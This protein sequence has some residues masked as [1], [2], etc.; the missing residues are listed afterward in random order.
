VNNNHKLQE[1]L[2]LAGV[3]VVNK[4]ILPSTASARV[5]KDHFFVLEG[6]KFSLLTAAF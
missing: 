3:F 4:I 2:N 6:R 5:K 1:Q